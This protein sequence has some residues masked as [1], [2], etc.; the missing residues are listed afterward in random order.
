M[1]LPCRLAAKLVAVHSLRQRVPASG[2]SPSV[3]EP[4]QQLPVVRMPEET[5]KQRLQKL[6]RKMQQHS[7]AFLLSPAT[8]FM[9]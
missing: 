2:G 6:R 7:R 4:P 3:L 1:V 8:P 5:P 9:R